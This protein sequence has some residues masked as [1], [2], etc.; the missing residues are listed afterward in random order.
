MADRICKFCGKVFDY[1]SYLN[2]HLKTK[3][4]CVPIF[5]GG[6]ES[7]DT[8][9]LCRFCGKGFKEETHMYRHVRTTC[10]IAPNARNGTQGLERLYDL[11]CERG[12]NDRARI[13]K[14]ERQNSDMLGMMRHLVARAP[15]HKVNIH[16][17]DTVAGDTVD[18]RK[19]NISIFGHETHA[20]ATVERIREIL[21][22]SMTARAIPSAIS[23]A[24]LKTAMLVYSDPDHPENLTCFLPNKK[25]N[26]VLVHG[27]KGWEVQPAAL[28]L[29]PMAQRSVDT[30][31]DMQPFENAGEYGPLMKE[32]A[33][34]EAR[35]IAGTELRPILIRNKDLLARALDSIPTLASIV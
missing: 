9:Y 3:R 17:G 29:P 22:E 19:I 7:H 6:E 20:H 32:L 10:K 8:T 23:A 33:D 12:E 31:F 25:T 18:N 11:V 24:V 26:D 14:L 13:E 28:V 34:N 27:E 30:L 15:N 5:A 21:D 2:R 35:Y 16:V 4:R 1:P